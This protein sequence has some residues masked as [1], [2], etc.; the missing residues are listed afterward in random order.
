[1]NTLVCLVYCLAGAVVLS[2]GCHEV[3]HS[4]MA[5][6]DPKYAGGVSGRMKVMYDKD[7][8]MSANIEIQMD[9][10]KLDMMK[11][12]KKYPNCKYPA[13]LFGWHLHA[14]WKNRMDSAFMDSCGPL[15][16]GGHYDPTFA[17]G[18]AS[19]YA[20]SKMC[21]ERTKLYRCTP[22][23][24]HEHGISCEMGDFSGK[25]GPLQVTDKNKM[26]LRSNVDYFFPPL[27]LRDNQWSLVV[28]LQCPEHGNPRIFCAKLV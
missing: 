20:N 25:F 9:L 8:P 18:K 19:Q 7:S 23:T 13:R 15:Y 1:M 16:T 21:K 24:Y 4:T 10:G 27:G 26:V 11:I 22:E 17:C 3:Q 5:I 6:L 28:H 14:L 2:H 12:Q